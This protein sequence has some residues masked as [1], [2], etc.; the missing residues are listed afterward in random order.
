VNAGAIAVCHAFEKSPAW[1]P[2]ARFRTQSR[3]IVGSDEKQKRKETKK[4]NETRTKN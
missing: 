2:E 3:D 1:K 4:T